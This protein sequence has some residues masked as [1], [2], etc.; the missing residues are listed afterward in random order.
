MIS[1]GLIDLNQFQN[2]DLNI[3]ALRQSGLVTLFALEYQGLIDDAETAA[4][5]IQATID[6][7]ALIGSGLVDL[8]DLVDRGLLD[9]VALEQT[10][11][12]LGDLVASELVEVED[13]LSSGLLEPLNFSIEN[14][15]TRLL[16]QRGLVDLEALLAQGMIVAG[17]LT[18]GAISLSELIDSELVAWAQLVESEVITRAHLVTD[19]LLRSELVG[20]SQQLLE[21]ISEVGLFG[22]GGIIDL[23]DLFDEEAHPILGILELRHL[24]YFGLIE[25]EDLPPLGTVDQ[26]SLLSLGL[27]DRSLLERVEIPD[28]IRLGYLTLQDLADNQLIALENLE[29]FPVQNIQRLQLDALTR[30]SANDLGLVIPGDRIDME[31][32]FER[33]GVTFAD[34]IE[35]GMLTLEDLENPMSDL[36]LG[37][38]FVMGQ[39]DRSALIESGLIE[40]AFLSDADLTPV[41]GVQM[42][43]IGALLADE[44]IAIELVDLI[45]AGLLSAS[46]FNMLAQIDENDLLVSGLVAPQQLDDNHLL[47]GDS[48]RHVV[49]SHLVQLQL[50]TLADLVGAGL[51]SAE[52]HLVT[53]HIEYETLRSTGKVAIS[54]LKNIGLENGDRIDLETLLE[55]LPIELESLE[56]A[57]LVDPS[58]YYQDSVVSLRKLVAAG[59]V[60]EAQI[61]EGMTVKLTELLASDVIATEYLS[62][63]ANDL[64]VTYSADSNGAPITLT[65][66]VSRGSQVQIQ[67]SNGDGVKVGARVVFADG[68]EAWILSVFEAGGDTAPTNFTVNLER[69]KSAGSEVTIRW[70]DQIRLS[71][72]IEAG[73]LIN[74]E[75]LAL[76]GLLG[77]EDFSQKVF[78]DVDAFEALI[79][80]DGLPLVSADQLEDIVRVGSVDIDDLLGSPLFRNVALV[81]YITSGFLGVNQFQNVS[82][83]IEDI[84]TL[85]ADWALETDEDELRLSALI[86]LLP[87][88]VGLETLVMDGF[89]TQDHLLS[90]TPVM[91]DIRDLERSELF[92]AGDLNN[93]ISSTE[94]WLSDLASLVPL[95]ELVSQGFVKQ[96]DIRPEVVSVS[97]QHLKDSNTLEQAWLIEQGLIEGQEDFVSLDTGLLAFTGLEPLVYFGI[98]NPG[99]FD[100]LATIAKHRL[101]EGELPVV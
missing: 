90:D 28:L 56:R 30:Q 16:L 23:N 93:F 59:L 70:E 36:T 101:L 29:D 72:L 94:I 7:Y 66:S 73:A 78:D 81:D 5:N 87:E 49:A 82:L 9:V 12:S 58:E 14:L 27:I 20:N 35:K 42:L 25:H 84:L 19:T 6:L 85:H 45:H 55:R 64:F 76:S 4:E 1:S 37:D 39:V 99:F 62:L 33:T 75:S 95:H 46:D 22:E 92:E 51:I 52:S 3:E 10:E 91:L 41:D 11:I 53:T 96:D 32:L 48:P 65:Q 21:Q 79:G 26:D 69:P 13:I 40:D 38:L 2:I 43:A 34:L 50:T 71:A 61:R 88:D 17:D 98:V 18:Q 44:D 89:L 68:E 54:T 8:I 60:D 15:S 47:Q 63:H 83:S 57:G 74:L 24:I 31:L 100:P 80:A 86:E 67:L 97:Y 77:F